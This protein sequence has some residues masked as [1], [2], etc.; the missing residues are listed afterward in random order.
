MDYDAALRACSA[1]AI[2]AEPPN[3]ILMPTS[4]PIAADIP[5]HE[6]RLLRL[7]DERDAAA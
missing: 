2:S 5:A 3:T 1:M 6:K 7:A 4:S